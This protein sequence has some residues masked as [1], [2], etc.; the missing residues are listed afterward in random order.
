ML[1]GAVGEGPKIL[2]EERKKTTAKELQMAEI[3]KRVTFWNCD[4]VS[5]KP[6]FQIKG[7]SSAVH[8]LIYIYT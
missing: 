1:K 2:P 8:Y 5:V 4:S 3:A 6:L 7:G